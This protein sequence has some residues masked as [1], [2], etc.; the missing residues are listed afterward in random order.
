MAKSH[1]I[2]NAF[3]R[4]ADDRAPFL[5]SDGLSRPVKRQTGWYDRT[6]LGH[7]GEKLIS[8]FDDAA[9]QCFFR[10]GFTYRARRDPGYISALKQGYRPGEVV[11]V[12]GVDTSQ[13]RLFALSLLWR[14][15]VS[16]LPI[17]AKVSMREQNLEDIRKRILQSSPGNPL[18]YPA[19]FCVFDSAE[20]LPKI[21]PF[22]PGTHPFYRF[23][24][25]GVV[26]Y[27]SPRR[28]LLAAP[29]FG[30]LIVG[31]ERDRFP[32]LCISS[33][34]SQHAQVAASGARNVLDIYGNVFR[35]FPH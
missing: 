4:K 33:S 17:M 11:E 30:R 6:I 31:T 5:E 9:S 8:R 13:L 15:A 23:F 28:T 32:L 18:E 2:P 1:I 10:R 21:Q 14:A 24:L 29:K 20:E 19:Y 34:S 35:G 26:A 7:R 27:V 25:D 3:M 12:E 22:R 16:G